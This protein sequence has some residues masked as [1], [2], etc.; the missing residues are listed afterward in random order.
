MFQQR[1]GRRVALGQSTKLWGTE[2]GVPGAWK[3]PL[4]CHTTLVRNKVPS[5]DRACELQSQAPST[6]LPACLP[7]PC[8]F[9]TDYSYHRPLPPLWVVP[10]RLYPLGHHLWQRNSSICPDHRQDHPLELQPRS[11]PHERAAPVPRGL[12]H[13]LDPGGP[14]SQPSE[15]WAHGFSWPSPHSQLGCLFCEMD[16]LCP[17][18]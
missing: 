6:L 10:T 17:S 5:R 12:D 13:S 15:Y 4:S 11:L 1:T 7:I 14:G 9:L 8:L 16:V 18:L 2:L 3:P